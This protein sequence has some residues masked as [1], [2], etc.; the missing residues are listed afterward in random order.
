MRD[1][2]SVGEGDKTFFIRVGKPLPSIHV[3][4]TLREA[5]KRIPTEHNI[6]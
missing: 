5:R 1:P 2:T 3:L 4:K 6:C